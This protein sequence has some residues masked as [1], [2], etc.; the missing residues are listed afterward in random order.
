MAKFTLY[1]SVQNGGD[2]SAY[3]Q[4]FET[5]R[6]TEM[7]QEVMS[8]G[9]GEPCNGIIEFEGDNIKLLRPKVTTVADFIQELEE[10]LEPGAGYFEY[11]DESEIKK[12]QEYLKELKEN[13]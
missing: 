5:E 4:F 1:Y 10:R 8:E 3:P 6:L 11:L 13:V 2:G 9:W 7:D 12:I